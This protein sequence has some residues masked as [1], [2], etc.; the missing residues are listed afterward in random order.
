MGRLV[1]LTYAVSAAL[2]PGKWRPLPPRAGSVFAEPVFVREAEA[3]RAF[4]AEL[5][6]IL[7]AQRTAL[8]LRE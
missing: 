3:L 8:E 1:D 7:A 4:D 6:A 2:E 5:P